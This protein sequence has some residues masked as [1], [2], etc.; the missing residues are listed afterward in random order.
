MYQSMQKETILAALLAPEIQGECVCVRD[1]DAW[2]S[3]AS[4]C[5]PAGSSML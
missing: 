4:L 3:P 5:S 1:E 2:A